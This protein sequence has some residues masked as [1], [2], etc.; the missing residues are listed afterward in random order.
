MSTNTDWGFK[1]K[2]APKQD[3]VEVNEVSKYGNSVKDALQSSIPG[4]IYKVYMDATHPLGFG[5]NG[6]YY[7]NKQD[8]AIYEPS[9]EV[10]N[11]GVIKKDSY[12]AGFVGYKAKVALQE[13][14]LMGVKNV[15]M[16]KLIYLADDVVYRNFWEGGKLILANAVFLNGK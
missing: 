5:T 2:E 7:T 16:G 15:G 10:W 4:S 6:V 13:G 1:L 8:V 9:K 11:V 3:K 12:V 14:V